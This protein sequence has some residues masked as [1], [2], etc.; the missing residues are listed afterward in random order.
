MALRDQPYLP[1]YVQDFM[2]DESLNECSAESTGVYIR[3]MC[4]MH[5]SK[6]YGMILLKHKDKQTDKQISN[7]ALKL[8]KQLPYDTATI[9]RALTELLEE[10]VLTLDG[11]TLYQKRMVKDGNLSDS[12]ASAGRKGGNKKQNA[13]QNE[14]FACDFAQ[15][16]TQANPENEYE[17]EN[18]TVNENEGTNTEN[19]ENGT[20]RVKRSER[21]FAPEHQAYKAAVYL[22]RRICRRVPSQKPA[23]ER[24]LQNWAD[25]FDK[26]HRLDGREWEEISRV[27]KFSQDDPFWQ[28]N[29]LSGK[30]FREKFLQLFSKMQGGNTR[31]PAGNNAMND[32]RD[33]Y[34]QFSEEETTT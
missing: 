1:L 11:D 30:K 10:E 21:N 34:E 24:T 16:K 9:E 6:N 29:I 17:Y 5:K 32:L 33:L 7:F 18:E 20:S 23:D 26:C 12:R 14:E 15:A 27:L 2:T 28:S 25:A 22:D 31:A 4:V 8:V 3:L 13:K 19:T